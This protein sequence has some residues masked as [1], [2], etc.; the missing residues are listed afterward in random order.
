MSD[1]TVGLNHFDAV[2]VRGSKFNDT[3]YSNM[4]RCANYSHYVESE[5]GLLYVADGQFWKECLPYNDYTSKLV[6]TFDDYVQEHNQG[7]VSDI[8]DKDEKKDTSAIRFAQDYFDYCTLCDEK[9]KGN[10]CLQNV[11]ISYRITDVEVAKDI[12]DTSTDGLDCNLAAILQTFVDKKGRTATN[13]AFPDNKEVLTGVLLTDT[14]YFYIIESDR[15]GYY[16]SFSE[17]LIFE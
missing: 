7:E 15:L 8:S 13:L 3:P 4:W 14:D 10:T 17:G 11:T 16:K 5:V 6:G 1:I 12:L 9:T 2:V